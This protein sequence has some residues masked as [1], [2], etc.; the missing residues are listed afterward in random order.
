[1]T[2]PSKPA[3]KGVNFGGS[4]NWGGS[5]NSTS[6]ATTT[7]LPT[8][9]MPQPPANTISATH[10]TALPV[11]TASK[12]QPISLPALNTGGQP[13]QLTPMKPAGINFGGSSLSGGIYGQKAVAKG[14]A[15][16][17]SNNVATVAAPNTTNSNM[18]MKEH[19]K[20]GAL[21]VRSIAEFRSMANTFQ[22]QF[23]K[24]MEE[25]IIE[26][27]RKIRE[28]REQA[29]KLNKEYGEFAEDKFKKAKNGTLVVDQALEDERVYFS[30]LVNDVMDSHGKTVEQF[31]KFQKMLD[32]RIVDGNKKALEAVFQQRLNEIEL[33][34]KALA[35]VQ[36][37]EKHTLD[38]NLV[39]HA[40][41]L[42][43]ETKRFEQLL[44]FV[45]KTTQIDQQQHEQV[46]D[47][48][49]LENERAVGALEGQIKAYQVQADVELQLKGLEQESALANRQIDAQKLYKQWENERELKVMELQDGQVKQQLGVQERVAL[50]ELALQ[51]SLGQ[52]ALDLRGEEIKA[53]KEIATTTIA[54]QERL[55]SKQIQAS[56]EYM[57]ADSNNRKDTAIETK[58]TEESGKTKRTA[59]REVNQTVRHYKPS[60]CSLQ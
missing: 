45:E 20:G 1:M 6:P 42:N 17:M 51:E 10:S 39:W 34:S 60:P 3:A 47:V 37:Q 28:Y 30:K 24:H 52:R 25:S 49:K 15:L 13:L 19:I 41:M 40:A 14:A 56:K 4:L 57:I 11:L 23:A 55:G 50:T 16:V 7:P 38:I 21:S 53:D 58:K 31:F 8:V 54:A 26:G 12:P 5:L 18:L 33:V 43:A 27:K 48:V 29:S 32:E 46:M 35:V 36:L 59:I 22:T 44:E 9:A 2:A